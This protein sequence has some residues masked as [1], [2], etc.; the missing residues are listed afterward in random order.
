MPESFEISAS[1][2]RY[3]VTVD[4]GL[5]ADALR[6]HAGAVILIDDRLADA[7]PAGEKKVIRVTAVE[8]SKSLEQAA[9][10]VAKL[11]ELGAHRRTHLLAIGGGIVQDVATFVASIYMRGISWSYLPTTLL[12][13]VDSCV[14]GKSSINVYDYKNLVGNFY[15]PAEVL[16]DLDFLRSLKAEQM[17]GGL[18]EA[19][20]ICYARS[21]E[22]FSAYLADAPAIDMAPARA[23]RIVVRSLRAKQ[24]FIEI[25]EF[26]QKER[27]LLNFGHTFGHALEAGTEFRISHGVAVGIG[28]VVA[29]EYAKQNALLAPAGRKCVERLTGHVELLLKELPQLADELRS[30]DIDLITEKFDNDKKH[31]ADQYRIVV[32]K[33]NGALELVGVARTEQGRMTIRKAYRAAIERLAKINQ[34]LMI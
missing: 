6:S 22:E 19:V 33:G 11:R 20:K 5:L 29:E 9:P 8:S 31:Q 2:G 13:M 27:L 1:S 25:D 23:E 10:I 14:G 26:D 32:P 16:I 24:W 28:M 34:L 7:L 17:I 12:G 4:S 21:A 18:C 15:P 30:L 3:Q